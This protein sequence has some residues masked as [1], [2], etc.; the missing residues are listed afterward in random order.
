M[1]ASS[2]QRL[3]LSFQGRTLES[4]TVHKR[5]IFFR[6]S[7]LSRDASLVRLREDVF[8]ALKISCLQLRL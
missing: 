7:S 5:C 2:L 8:A 4:P 1:Q 6:D 3:H